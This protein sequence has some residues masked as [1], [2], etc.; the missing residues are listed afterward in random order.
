MGTF[1]VVYVDFEATG[2]YQ[3]ADIVEI[4]AVSES[5]STFNLFLTTQEKF[6]TSAAQVT[7]MSLDSNNRLLKNGQPLDTVSREEGFERFY[8]YLVEASSGKN[9]IVLVTHG[10]INF[11]IPLLRANIQRLGQSMW[12]RFDELVYSFDDTF[13]FAKRNKFRLRLKRLGLLNIAQTLLGVP[14]E[15]RQH[16][17][18]SDA[19]LTKRVA[20]AMKM[21]DENMSS[22][23]L[24]WDSVRFPRDIL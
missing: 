22:R 17:A 11:D 16:G 10:G 24:K 9:K 20:E 13:V 14:I 15:G 4:G 19:L 2:L 5:G 3:K 1:P 23:L 12:E 7:G 8:E 6:T 18:L 21:N